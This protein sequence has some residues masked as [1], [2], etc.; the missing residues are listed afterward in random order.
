M[1]HKDE[2]VM[3]MPEECFPTEESDRK[4]RK[5]ELCVLRDQGRW[6]TSEVVGSNVGGGGRA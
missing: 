3:W 4:A 6:S 2:G 5:D 1:K